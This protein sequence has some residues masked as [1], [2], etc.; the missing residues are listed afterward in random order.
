MARWRSGANALTTVELRNATKRYTDAVID[1]SLRADG[2]RQLVLLGP[3]GS[4][5][6]TI[7]RMIAGLVA[8]DSGSVTFDGESMESVLPENREA[9]MVFQDHALFPFH[10]VAENVGYGLKVRK[11]SAGERSRRVGEALAAVHLDGFEDRWPGDLS[12]GERQ[13][14]ALARAIVVEPRVLLLDEPLSSLDPMLRLELQ[15]LICDVQ[16]E[17]EITSIFVTHDLDEA[18]A[19]ADDVA[20]ILDGTVAQYGAPEDVFDDPNSD[21]VAAFLGQAPEVSSS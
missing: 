2:G 3:S 20:V 13:R 4:G 10:T 1:A 8:P 5:K 19:V 6:S 11:V 16:R 7:L 18:R 21:R 17:F 15:R 12:G 9:V 14:V